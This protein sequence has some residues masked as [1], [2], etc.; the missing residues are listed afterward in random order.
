MGDPVVMGWKEYEESLRDKVERGGLCYSC[1]GSKEQWIQE[2]NS[3]PTYMIVCPACN[4]SGKRE[5]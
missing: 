1:D 2:F 4:G 5:E 3:S